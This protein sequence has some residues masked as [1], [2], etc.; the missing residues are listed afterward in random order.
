MIFLLI[1]S[2]WQKT[3]ANIKKNGYFIYS[4]NFR[5][6]KCRSLNSIHKVGSLL[7]GV[8]HCGAMALQWKWLQVSVQIYLCSF[9]HL[10][11]GRTQRCRRISW[12]KSDWDQSYNG[13]N[14]PGMYR[15]KKQKYQTFHNISQNIKKIY[16]SKKRRIRL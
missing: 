15:L 1:A 7:N 10:P 6:W 8:G 5:Y 12:R 4:Y 14:F 11:P 2:F 16:F 9:P 3:L 13:W